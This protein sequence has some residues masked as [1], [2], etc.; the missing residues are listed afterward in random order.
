MGHS[1]MRTAIILALADV[2]SARGPVVVGPPHSEG[3]ELTMV[4]ALSKIYELTPILWIDLPTGHN[5]KEQRLVALMDNIQSV[6]H[7]YQDLPVIRPVPG[8]STR[9]PRWDSPIHSMQAILRLGH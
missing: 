6:L 4:W 2:A 1:A 9:S 5:L 7:T 8:T 3:V